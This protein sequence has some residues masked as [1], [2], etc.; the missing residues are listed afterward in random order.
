MTCAMY[1]MLHLERQGVILFLL[2]NSNN[3]DLTLQFSEALLLGKGKG[4]QCACH[5]GT[6][7]SGGV[8][9]PL[10]NLCTER[11]PSIPRLLSSE[12]VSGGET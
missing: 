12:K 4:F 8:G 5:E 6:W 11:S 1:T 9:R 3:I 2:N 10:L 7:G